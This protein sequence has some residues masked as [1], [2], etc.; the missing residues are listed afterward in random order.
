MILQ[1]LGKTKLNNR[2]DLFSKLALQLKFDLCLQLQGQIFL[3][4]VLTIV[5]SSGI[6]FINMLSNQ[7]IMEIGAI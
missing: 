7:H 4:N 6:R 3:Q 2:V 5:S 1:A